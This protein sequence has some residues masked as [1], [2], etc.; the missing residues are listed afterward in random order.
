MNI[1]V[2][3]HFYRCIKCCPC[4]LLIVKTPKSGNC[5]ILEPTVHTIKITNLNLVDNKE[6]VSQ[7]AEK[8]ENLRKKTLHLNYD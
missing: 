2:H 1:Q 3:Q 7:R 5:K 6:Q 4:R 8:I